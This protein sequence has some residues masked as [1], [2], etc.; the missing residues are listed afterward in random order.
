MK[1][2]ELIKRLQQ[3]DPASN[4]LCCD[5]YGNLMEDINVEKPTKMFCNTTEHKDEF[6]AK[7]KWVQANDY[8]TGQMVDKNGNVTTNVDECYYRVLEFAKVIAKLKRKRKC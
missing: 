3:L 8:E 5:L 6:N 7:G 1:V 2:N 4:I